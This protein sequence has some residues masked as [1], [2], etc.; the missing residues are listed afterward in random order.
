[1]QQLNVVHGLI[2][3]KREKASFFCEGR[4][5]GKHH[6][7]PFPKNG[8]HRACRVGQIIHSDVIGP[9]Q[10]A[11]QVGSKYFVTFTDDYSGYTT[12]KIMKAKSGLHELREL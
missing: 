4:V 6:R 7:L 11:S 1:M 12:V 2:I 3:K 10:T 8:H 5:M 9:I